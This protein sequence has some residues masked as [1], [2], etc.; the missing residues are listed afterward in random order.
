[1]TLR[2]GV[3]SVG[4]SDYGIYFPVL[5]LL[6]NDPAIELKLIVFDCTDSFSNLATVQDTE[7]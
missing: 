1:M 7:F 6:Q 5:R 2:V 4:R 3:V